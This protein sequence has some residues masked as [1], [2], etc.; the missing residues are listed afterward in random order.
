MAKKSDTPT[1]HLSAARGSAASAAGTP[2]LP[3]VPGA[4]LKSGS[5]AEPEPS[6]AA[7][8][9]VPAP[10]WPP[11]DDYLDEPDEVS[12]WERIGGV[13]K[14]ASPATEDHGDPHFELDALVKA[15]LDKGYIGSVDL[16][17]RVSKKHEYA[18]DTCVRRAGIDPATGRRYLE[19][20]V[21]EVVHKRSAKETKARAKGFAARGVRRQIGIFA[22]DK[23][24]REW[25]EGE[26][27]WGQPL[28]SDPGLRDPCLAV[29]LPFAAFFDPALAEEAIARALEAKGDPVI[30]E[31][32]DKSEK[33]GE[34]RG[35]KRGEKRGLAQGKAEGLAEGETRGRAEALLTILD[36][37]GFALS[38][39]VRE[40]ILAT[41][42]RETLDRWLRRA[43]AAS[44]LEEV[45]GEV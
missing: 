37:R 26:A 12:R 42:D 18:S 16:K 38:K 27:D 34:I 11:V 40:R 3:Y 14:E 32:K 36:A 17:T 30:L 20:L 1:Y 41:T 6:P 39:E 24:V 2:G 31:I 44:A 13:R 29:P 19:E 7:T 21:F 10:A 15:H 22:K 8:A 9:P 23:T 43:A 25:L 4:I 35:K 45:T 5:V 28:D 33:R